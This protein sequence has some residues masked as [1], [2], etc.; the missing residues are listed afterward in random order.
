MVQLRFHSLK[1]F[2]DRFCSNIAIVSSSMPAAPRLAFTCWYASHT[3]RFA[4]QYGFVDVMS[5]IPAGRVGNLNR[6][7][8]AAPWL[9]PHYEGFI[10]TAGS[11]VPRPGIGI[12]PHGVCHL[13][14][15]L[16][17][18]TR[19]SRSVPK[20]VLSSCRLYT[21]CHR[22]RKQV[23]SRLILELMVGPSFDSSLNS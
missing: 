21:D 22:D 13:S 9:H 3:V 15:P 7:D 6:P 2:P 19:F 18:R 10:T 4:M 14:F 20:P 23:S 12:L 11:S 17:S 8:N 1:R 16:P 5:L